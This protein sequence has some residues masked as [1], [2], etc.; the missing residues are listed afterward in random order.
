MLCFPFS[1]ESLYTNV[2]F[3]NAVQCGYSKAVW[4]MATRACPHHR[5]KSCSLG[6]KF[7]A[8]VLQTEEDL[9][10][11]HSICYRNKLD[12]IKWN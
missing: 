7:P 1:P 4:D 2:K 9:D 3:C 11:N 8:G 10:L 12:V 6:V 5:Q